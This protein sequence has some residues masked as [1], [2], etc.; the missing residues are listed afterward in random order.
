MKT[1]ETETRERY[2]NTAAYREHEQKTKNYT[3][4]IRVYE[5]K[6]FLELR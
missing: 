1:Y 6:F 3:I 5:K 2:G 4:S